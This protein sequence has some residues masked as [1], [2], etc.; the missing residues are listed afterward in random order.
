MYYIHGI[1]G[2][3]LLIESSDS[4]TCIQTSVQTTCGGHNQGVVTSPMD[5]S[6][7]NCI[8]KRSRVDTKSSFKA[9]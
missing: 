4:M 5:C 2:P 1:S 7:I 6:M 8:I 3:S 9:E